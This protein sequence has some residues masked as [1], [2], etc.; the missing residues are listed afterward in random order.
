M[1]ATNTPWE[2]DDAF[3]RRF[4]KR[5]YIHLPD[6]QARTGQF[7]LKIRGVR[8]S[9]TEEQY[10]QL[11]QS[12]ELYSGSDIK[13]V[14]NEALFMPIRKCQNAT[15]F[16]E[17][18]GK[19]SPCSPSD[20]RGKEMEMYDVP[21]GCL[22]EPEVCYDDYMKALIKIKP[23]CAVEDLKAYEEFTQKYGQDG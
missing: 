17:E 15:K 8:N 12:S 19:F 2:L 23:S 20:P 13:I 6:Q 3:R 7:K 14:S 11:G 4:Q 21:N 18:N 1:G 22:V 5:I 9:I 16:I 10:I